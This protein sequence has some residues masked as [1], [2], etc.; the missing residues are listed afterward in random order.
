MWEYFNPNPAGRMVGDCSVRAV[1]AALGISWEK[2]FSLLCTAAYAMCDMPSS[3]AVWGSVLRR[4]KFYR[5]ALPNT[6]PECYTAEAFAEEHPNGVYVL[7][8]GGHVAT[9]VDG[10]VLL[11]SW[12]SSQEIVI[13]Y[14]SKEET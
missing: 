2:A 4:H 10:G 6:C 13:Y 8:F 11:D 14:W 3:D 5:H 1:S 9:V 12:D 7:S